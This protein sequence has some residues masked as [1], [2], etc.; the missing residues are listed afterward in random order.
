MRKVFCI[1]LILLPILVSAQLNDSSS[2][3]IKR[4]QHQVGINATSFLLQFL[5]FN[6]SNINNPQQF[7]TPASVD[8]KFFKNKPGGN[9]RIGGRFGLGFTQSNQSENPSSDFTTKQKVSNL[10]ARAGV[11]IQQKIITRWTVYYGLDLIYQTND[12]EVSTTFSNGQEFFS[13]TT[14]E[15]NTGSGAGPVL[16]VQF[17]INKKLSLSTETALYYLEGHIKTNNT[18]NIPNGGGQM[19][20]DKISYFNNFGFISPTFVN[21]NITL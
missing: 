9:S 11:E 18:T 8:Y 17:N 7:F 2:Q 5:S 19:P 21:F 12:R 14:M 20:K 1:L 4:F 16:G 15:N 10:S 6:N 13:T 3:N